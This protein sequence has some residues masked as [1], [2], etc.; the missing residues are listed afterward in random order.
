MRD[1]NTTQDW[2][3]EPEG[4]DHGDARGNEDPD[5]D[6]YAA[7]THRPQRSQGKA[8]HRHPRACV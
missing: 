2:R 3:E 6:R 5:A 7:A 4:V 1:E 8:T